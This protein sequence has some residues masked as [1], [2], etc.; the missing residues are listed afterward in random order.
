MVIAEVFPGPC[1][2]EAVI[3]A[4]RAS[5]RTIHVKI[6][7]SYKHVKLLG[8]LLSEVDINKCIKSFDD[9]LALNPKSMIPCSSR[10]IPIAISKMHRG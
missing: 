3:E 1:K 9:N 2:F 7:N 5:G 10:V 4:P 6:K 8:V